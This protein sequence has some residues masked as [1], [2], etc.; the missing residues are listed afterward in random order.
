MKEDWIYQQYVKELVK[1][2]EPLS[3]E[4]LIRRGKCCGNGCKNCP[5][6]PKHK[7]GNTN[8]TDKS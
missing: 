3:A 2:H 1:K 5:Y 8:V 4:F 7:K 6:T